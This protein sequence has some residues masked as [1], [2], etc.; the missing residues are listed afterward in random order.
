MVRARAGAGALLTVA[1]IGWLTGFWFVYDGWWHR[2][3][4]WWFLAPTAVI[5]LPL[6]WRREPWDRWCLITAAL[7]LF[8]AL[9]RTW[10]SGETLTEVA[11]MSDTLA[12]ALLLTALFLLARHF[13]PFRAAYLMAL[14]LISAVVM[15]ASLP[16]FYSDHAL[17]ADRFCDVFV[18]ESGLNPILTGLLCATAA[19]HA[20]ALLA[21]SERRSGK[22]L[23]GAVLALHVFALCATQ[24]RTPMIAMVVGLGALGA[25]QRKHALVPV[26]TCVGAATAYYLAVLL[27]GTGG[28]G[29]SDLVARGSTGR[30]SIYQWFL[31]DM[32]LRSFLI[33][34]GMA[35]PAEIPE[36]VLGW[37]VHHPHSSYLTQLY[38]T[39]L[40]GLALLAAVLAIA[41]HRAFQL[42]R[43]GDAIWLSLLAGHALAVAVDGAQIFS[44]QSIPRIEFILLAVPATLAVALARPPAVKGPEAEG[45]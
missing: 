21:A 30:L 25:F 5:T 6:V 27:P 3:F 8:Q 24:S 18:Y 26:L 33:G 17:A 10:S 31:G 32:G 22:I 37:F 34:R 15:G 13:L 29:V 23:W 19:L 45:P 7:L 28:D 41:S 40:V 39:G 38:L 35:S 14:P 42:A 1:L 43:K 9:S 20:A 4:F 12:V 2:R 16:L 44:L 36:D 11:G